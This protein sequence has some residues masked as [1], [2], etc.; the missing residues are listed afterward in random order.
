MGFQISKE[1]LNHF[2]NSL[3]NDYDIYAPIV[4]EGGGIFSDT[5]CIRYAKINSIEEI[6][7]LK[8]ISIPSSVSF[9]KSLDNFQSLEAIC[10]SN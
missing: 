1:G 4:F 3:K 10:L 6:E 2:F 8:L 5:D 7:R 9:P